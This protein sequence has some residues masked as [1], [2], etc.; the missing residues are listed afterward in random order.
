MRIELTESQARVLEEILQSAM[1]DMRMEIADT[2]NSDF[3]AKLRSEKE[4]LQAI[5]DQVTAGHSG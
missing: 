1:S 4:V 5:L 3:K 2:D